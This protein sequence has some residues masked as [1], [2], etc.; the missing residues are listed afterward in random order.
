MCSKRG[1]YTIDARSGRTSPTPH[2]NATM[3]Q[4]NDYI[5]VYVGGLIRLMFKTTISLF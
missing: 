5:T 1:H 3:S 4:Y 2:S